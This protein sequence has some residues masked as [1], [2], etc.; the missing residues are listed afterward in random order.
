MKA[1]VTLLVL[2]ILLEFHATAEIFTADVHETFRNMLVTERG[3]SVVLGSNTSLRR[4]RSDHLSEL[5]KVSLP[6]G[7]VNRLLI[8]VSESVLSCAGMRCALLDVSDLTI[9][10]WEHSSTLLLGEKNADGLIFEGKYGQLVLTV[11]L[12]NEL[13]PSSITRGR[14]AGVGSGVQEFDFIARQSERTSVVLRQFLLVFDNGEFSYFVSKFEEETRVV[15]ICNN[16]TTPDG[17]FASYFEIKLACGDLD[18][19]PTAASYSSLDQTIT[20]S[21]VRGEIENFMCIFEISYINQLMTNK[22]DSCRAGL[23]SSGLSRVQTFPCVEFVGERLNN[24]VSYH[25]Q[26]YLCEH[27]MCTKLRGMNA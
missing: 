16:D 3:R 22:Y 20:L 4:L 7:Q 11:A 13:Q 25:K 5:Q 10:S 18:T 8:G 6:E 1:V 9:Q 23:G 12:Q 24:P 19:V 15:R 26:S 14:I 27:E 2:R 17:D 21:V